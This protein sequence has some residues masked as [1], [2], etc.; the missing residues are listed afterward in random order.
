MKLSRFLCLFALSSLAATACVD[1]KAIDSDFKPAVD[2]PEGPDEPT[3]GPAHG[4]RFGPPLPTEP[5][6]DCKDFDPL[7]RAY[8]GDLHVHTSYSLD[9]NVFGNQNNDPIAAHAFARGATLDLPGGQS[10]TLD[11]KLDFSVVSDHAEF[12]DLIGVCSVIS[13]PLADSEY[14]KLL[15]WFGSKD[16]GGWAWPYIITPAIDDGV[17]HGI[18]K[19]NP[20]ACEAARLDLWQRT[21]N[22]AKT[23]NQ[24]CEYTALNAFE[25]S[26]T[27]WLHRVVVFADDNVP[28]FP[29]DALR[30]ETPDLMLEEL[31]KRCRPEDGC[32][33]LSIPHNPNFTQGNMWKMKDLKEAK[34]R[35][36]FERLVEVFQIK[37]NSECLNTSDP[38]DVGYDSG[39][40]FEIV[41]DKDIP[42][43]QAA[44]GYV[45]WGLKAGLLWHGATG[46]NPLQMGMVAAT[47]THNATG[48]AVK[49]DEPT[50]R[51]GYG[52]VTAAQRLGVGKKTD[53]PYFNPGGITGVWAEQ[54]T[55]ESIFSAMQRRETFGTSG[56]RI[57]VRFYQT[58]NDTDHCADPA[59]PAA[60]SAT[61]V[62]MGGSMTP[63]DGGKPRFVISAIKDQTDLAEIHIIKAALHNGQMVETVTVVDTISPEVACVTWTDPNYQADA[64]AFYYVRV[65]E[66]EVY[67]WS[68]Y[69]CETDET[70]KAYCK[71]YP[72]LDRKIQERAW[73][74]PIWNLPAPSDS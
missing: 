42:V 59:F 20:E 70:T 46:I 27:E 57:Q 71:K 43:A 73:T 62:P 63:V 29:L 4:M 3:E 15:R 26:S 23:A 24:P 40:D 39:C 1:T 31:E 28:K 13:G 18:C 66:K 53:D 2:D 48:G 5:P 56:P 61:G 37:G 9:A 58:W 16:T 68:H 50:G 72:G 74:S 41:P 17:A 44:K 54:N 6:S 7:K 67:R 30:F 34:R 35:G 33:A 49:E 45:R 32:K 47:D 60:L 64:P 55:R 8:F 36:E 14:C 12:L 38:G 22:A 69:D 52:D 25:W 21:Q 19:D 10:V 65:L 11:R 51:H